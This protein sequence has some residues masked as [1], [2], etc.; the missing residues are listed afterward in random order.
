MKKDKCSFCKHLIDDFNE[1]EYYMLNFKVYCSLKC[2]EDKIKKV[3]V[4]KVNKKK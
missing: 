2:Y 1:N 4:K 3:P